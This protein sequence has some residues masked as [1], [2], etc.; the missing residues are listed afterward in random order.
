MSNFRSS[1][2]M[3]I[4][5]FVLI[6]PVSAQQIDIPRV[7]LMPTMPEPY[8]I[9]DW[10]TVAL[11][12]DSLVFDFDR[13]G[14]YLPLIW[15]N[16]NPVNYPEHESFGLETVVGTPRVHSGE[17]INILPAVIGATLAGIDK[18]NQNG[19]NWVLMCEEFFQNRPEENIYLNGYVTSSGDDWWYETMPNIFF[20]QLYDLYPGTGDFDYQFTTVADQWFRAVDVMGG[21]TTP[22][23]RAYLN[24]RAFSFSEMEPLNEGVPEPEAAGAIAWILYNAYVETGNEE[25]RIGA[26]WALEFLD[27][28]S[29]NPSYEIQHPYGVYV[30]ARMNAELGTTYDIEQLVNWVFEITPLRSW[31]AILGQWGDYDVHG[32]IGEISSN[33]YA[34]MMNGYETLGALIP[35]VRYDDRFS[36]DIG[37]WANNLVNASRF[38]YPN[39][40]PPENQDSEDWSYE[41]DPNSCIGHEA[42]REE[43]NSHSPYA[44]GDAIAGGWGYTNLVLYGSSHVGI[45]AGIVDTTNV[46]GILQLDMSCTDYFQD[47]SY[48]TYLYYNPHDAEADVQVSLGENS[49]DLYD[50]VTNSFRSYGQTGT[51]EIT[52]NGGEAVQLVLVPAGA[53]VTYQYNNTLADGVIIDY[54]SGIAVENYPPRIKSLAADPVRIL[55]DG[56]T[57]VYCTAEDRD[58]DDLTYTWTTEYGVT[59]E[60]TGILEWPAPNEAGFFSITCVV[61][62]EA[63]LAD[64]SFVTIEV[65]DNLP[66][67]I[68]SLSAD[69]DIVEP[70]GSTTLTCIASDPDE[71]PLEY[72]WEAEYGT[73]SGEGNQV[74]WQAPDA[75]GFYEISCTVDDN[76]G[77]TDTDQT[78]VVIGNLVMHHLFNNNVWDSSPFHNHGA[79]YGAEFVEDRLGN[80]SYALLFDGDDDR[81]QV[82]LHQSLAFSDEITVAFW[83]NIAQHYDREQFPISHGSWSNRWKVSIIP[84]GRV[85]WTVNTSAG[86]YDVDSDEPLEAGSWYHVAALYENGN[87]R[88]YING[89]EVANR[90]CNGTLSQTDFDITIGQMLPGDTQYNFH[91]TMDEVRLYNHVITAAEIESLYNGTSDAPYRNDEIPTSFNLRQNYPNPFNGATIIPFEVPVTSH[92]QIDIYNLRGQLV[93]TILSQHVSAGYHNAIWHPLNAVSGAYFIRF[94]SEGMDYTRRCILLK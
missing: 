51:S 84:D 41:Y 55:I 28:R 63:G 33:D 27:N 43:Y 83:M 38:F 8:E 34:F 50:A 7:Q 10:R 31:G 56:E 94:R 37:R 22:W 76:N 74:S 45:L 86:I 72:Q 57:T 42:M 30:A 25:Y 81:V 82:P 73:F 9:R 80:E 17:A 2:W 59:E 85:R 62:D 64:T 92:V 4:L 14:E 40:L 19:E 39:Y 67:V 79:I 77:G 53:S 18:S 66:P 3:I 89:S 13:T 21:D 58:D 23:H 11:G 35:M 46:E 48:Q 87:A 69:P 71:D 93:D 24:Y 75:E 49:Y 15:W 54:N 91:G 6:I 47:N 88:L 68:T 20:Y 5:F 78:G 1:F 90:S 60:E 70:N 52:I 12:Y 32:L 16:P 65:L 36:R 29:S 44:T 61:S 26:E